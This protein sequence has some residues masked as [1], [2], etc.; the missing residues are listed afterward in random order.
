M[1]ELLRP[2]LCVVAG[3]NGSGKTSTTEK[4]LSNEW[5]ADSVYI[6][7]DNI[8]QETY[9]DWNSQEAILNA[10]KEATRLRYEYLQKRVNFVFETVFSS[11]EKLDFLKK[12]HNE[13]FFIRFFYVC[14]ESPE[15]NVLRVAQ[16]Y[17]N[18]GH[19]VPMS[20]IFSRYYKS[21]TLASQA[22]LFVDRAYVYDNSRDNELPRLLYRTLNGKIH[23]RYTKDIPD[24]ADSLI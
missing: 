20:K 16:R 10:A 15:I 24:W 19:E 5:T 9:G 6:N 21:L 3:P 1:K 2:V 17:L 14:T 8:A 23:K 4:L 13:G 18:G 7:P 12:A 11:Q 22:I